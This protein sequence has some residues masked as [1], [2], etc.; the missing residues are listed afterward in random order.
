MDCSPPGFSVHEIL[1]AGILEW[2]VLQI[3]SFSTGDLVP[4]LGRKPGPL[5]RLYWECGVLATGPLGKSQKK[6]FKI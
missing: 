5:H 1:Q 4:L 6:H 3:L 2:A